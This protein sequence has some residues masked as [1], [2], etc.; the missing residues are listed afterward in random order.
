MLWLI[1]SYEYYKK[2]LRTRFCKGEGNI[3]T[4][5]S[6]ELPSF[7]SYRNLNTSST[8]GGSIEK[9]PI[10]S[11]AKSIDRASV[12]DMVV[13][14]STLARHLH[15]STTF[16]STPTSTNCSTPSSVEIY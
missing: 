16:F 13:T 4:W 10:S 9:V 11:I 8:P 1:T 6:I 2:T 12:L 7:F 15:L 3:N 14:S 5:L